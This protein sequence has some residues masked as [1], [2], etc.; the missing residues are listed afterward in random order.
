LWKPLFLGVVKDS[1]ELELQH[2]SG[3]SGGITWFKTPSSSLSAKEPGFCVVLV[4]PQ[5]WRAA[6][7][8]TVT[9]FRGLPSPL[10][11]RRPRSC[12]RCYVL[13]LSSPSTSFT[14]YTTL[15]FE[16]GLLNTPDSHEAQPKR[17]E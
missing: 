5:T 15:D 8:L 10:T 2:G 12:S 7:Q 3:D 1:T 4:R 6:P 11:P 14:H 13:K 16:T 9:S 17:V